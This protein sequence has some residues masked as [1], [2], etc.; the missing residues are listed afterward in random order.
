MFAWLA[1]K[2]TGTAKPVKTFKACH[3]CEA[4]KGMLV[5]K[6]QQQACEL[7]L[8]TEKTLTRQ[9]ANLK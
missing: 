7:P 2:Q 5:Y 1:T 9:L 3:T 8:K 6:D 4:C